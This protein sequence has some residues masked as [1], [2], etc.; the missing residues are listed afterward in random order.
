MRQLP[1]QGYNPSSELS[2][3]SHT[4]LFHPPRKLDSAYCPTA[5]RKP[6]DTGHADGSRYGNGIFHCSLGVKERDL[7]HLAKVEPAEV[8]FRL[9]LRSKTNSSP[10]EVP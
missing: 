5:T 10:N 1:L 8:S 2:P 7:F 4:P 6:P 9:V 3:T